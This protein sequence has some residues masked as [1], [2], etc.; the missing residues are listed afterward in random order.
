MES[1][2]HLAELLRD[3]KLKVTT[4][5]LEVLSVI[6]SFNKAIPFSEIQSALD[7]FDR[8][9]LYRT[10]H[11]LQESGI[12]HRALVDEKDIFYAMCNNSCSSDG[13]NHNHIHF[14][15][16]SCQAVTCVQTGGPIRLLVPGHLIDNF[17]IEAMGICASCNY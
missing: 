17:Q 10:L 1:S 4:N 2:N 16:S 9:T 3:R 8:V 6:T 11:A 15:C 7:G 5:R 14:K 12:I 13:H